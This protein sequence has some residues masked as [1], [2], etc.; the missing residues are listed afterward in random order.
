MASNLESY[1]LLQVFSPLQFYQIVCSWENIGSVD[2]LPYNAS[3]HPQDTNNKN[4]KEN[5][6]RVL[7]TNNI[8]S[9]RVFAGVTGQ[10]QISAHKLRSNKTDKKSKHMMQENIW[11]ERYFM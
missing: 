7:Q 5:I 3:P 6:Q 8:N 11:S 10:F 1:A 9:A 4:R 2:S